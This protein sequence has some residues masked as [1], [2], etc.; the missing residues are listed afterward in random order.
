MAF[1]RPWKTLYKA[2]FSEKFLETSRK[3]HYFMKKT[4]KSVDFLIIL[5]VKLSETKL[6]IYVTQKNF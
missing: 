3:N 4:K 5:F 1:G 2:I 6:S